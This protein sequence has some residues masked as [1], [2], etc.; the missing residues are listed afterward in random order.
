VRR[1]EPS[2]VTFPGSS[3]HTRDVRFVVYGAGAV[4]GVVGGRLHE[5]GHDT[6]LIAR[7]AHHDAIREHGLRLES[8][9]GAVTLPVPVVDHPRRLELGDDDVVLLAM[10][11]QHT[12]AAL[13]DLAGVAP[14]TLAV[15]CLQNGVENER[16]ALRRFTE[17]HTVCVM[18]PANHLEPG[19]VQAASAPV[20]GLLD[21]GRWPAGTDATTEAVA[22]AF[23]SATFSSEPRADVARWK[24]A[25]LLLNLGNAVDALCPRSSAARDL[26]GR[27][28]AEGEA[29]LAAAGI[30][31]AS[32]EE[33]AARRGDLVASR[34]VGGQP[35]AGGST[36]Q[37]L[38]RGVGNVE[39]DYLNG[40]IVLRGRLHGVP[41]PVNALLQ[42]L[43][44][45]AAR[46]GRQPRS[47]DAAE[48]LR[49]LDRG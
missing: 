13:D 47:L 3:W 43:A 17:V 9:D 49:G 46:T 37:S 25:K 23:S 32:A 26:S 39:T 7:G 21:I 38:T 40:E 36:L 15:V 19:V 12:A 42:Q 22:A 24:Y 2:T 27:A 30:D 14:P 34:P 28:R 10:K 4:G 8:P 18:C 29:V 11:T 35:R 5:A 20:S 41:T 33:E 1:S 45:D 48:V 16:L 6:V 31:H 44:A